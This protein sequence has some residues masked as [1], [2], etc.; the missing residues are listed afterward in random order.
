MWGRNLSMELQTARGIGEIPRSWDQ[1]SGHK[2][3][4]AC[5]GTFGMSSEEGSHI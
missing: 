3:R 5:Q 2:P 4:N 1:G